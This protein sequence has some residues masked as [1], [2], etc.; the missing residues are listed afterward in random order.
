MMSESSFIIALGKRITF[1]REKAGLTECG[2]SG[3]TGIT[4]EDIIAYEKGS[5]SIQVEDFLKIIKALDIDSAQLMA[6]I[7]LKK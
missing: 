2:L 3:I 5:L 1:Y 7:T 4:I 6:G